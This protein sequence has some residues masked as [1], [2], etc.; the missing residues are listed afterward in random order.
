MAQHSYKEFN[1][2]MSFIEKRTDFSVQ[3][4]SRKK[5]TVKITYLPEN[6]TMTTHAGDK[7]YHPIRRFLKRFNIII[8]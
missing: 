5:S 8:Q 7:A 6:M 4:L 2:I 1:K 3:R